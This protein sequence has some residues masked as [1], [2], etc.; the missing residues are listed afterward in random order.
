MLVTA[1]DV[2]D[3]ANDNALLFR[4]WSRPRRLRDEV[5]DDVGRLPIL[6]RESLGIM[7][8]SRSAGGIVRVAATV[9]QRP[10]SQGPIHLHEPSDSFTCPQGQTLKFILIQ[11]TNGVPLRL[12]RSFEAVCQVCPASS[13]YEAKEIG[14][15]LAIG[16]HDAVLAVIVPGCPPQQLERPYK[17]K[18]ATGSSQ[19]SES[20]RNN[21]GTEVP[22]ARLV[23]RGGRVDYAC[24]S[25][26]LAHSLAVWALQPLH[27]SI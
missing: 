17:L 16:P 27:R 10:I 20:S 12:Y 21:R 3:A 2:V 1:V 4:C 14:R 23:K 25:L 8:P 19:S 26:Q 7:R 22:T 15:S 24:H 9:P 18:K 5:A 11:H 13:L 6:R